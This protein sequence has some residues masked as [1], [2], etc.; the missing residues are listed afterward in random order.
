MSTAE[1]IESIRNGAADYVEKDPR[2]LVAN[3]F[4]PVWTMEDGYPGPLPDDIAEVFDPEDPRD[5]VPRLVGPMS[6]L[7]WLAGLDDL[8]AAI[9]SPEFT[10]QDQVIRIPYNARI[11]TMLPLLHDEG[12]IP[13][14]VYRNY[15]MP[16]PVLSVAAFPARHV[17][18]PPS[19]TSTVKTYDLENLFPFCNPQPFPQQVQ[20]IK[21]TQEWKK[22]RRCRE[23]QRNVLPSLGGDLLFRGLSRRALVSSMACLFPV[24]SPHNMDQ[25]FGPG[26]YTTPSLELALEY[27]GREGAVMVFRNPDFRSLEVWEPNAQEWSTV[28][29]YWTGRP[30]SNPSQQAPSGW[31]SADVIKGSTTKEAPR[32]GDLLVPSNDTQVVVRT[33]PATSLLAASLALIIW[34]D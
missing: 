1:E 12:R 30:L 16:P 17:P 32:G 33:C 29:R 14:A 8:V 2:D 6:S 34:F 4:R 27:A 19:I 20:S 26:I 10:M 3:G 11:R 7:F 23:I 25:D 9:D 5:K 21:I 24:I 18:I 13:G 28:T 31:K 22:S 15:L